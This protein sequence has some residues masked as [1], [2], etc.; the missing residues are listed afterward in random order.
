[1]LSHVLKCMKKEKSPM[2]DSPVPANQTKNIEFIDFM[3]VI[4]E[5]ELEKIG[6]ERYDINCGLPEKEQ[7]E[8]R[9][10]I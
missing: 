3:N 5:Q 7:V 1:M 4:F 8:C 10:E 6:T 9:G 2:I